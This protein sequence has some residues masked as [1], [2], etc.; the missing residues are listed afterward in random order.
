MNLPMTARISHRLPQG[1]LDLLRQLLLMGGAYALYCLVRGL[2]D[3]PAGAAVAFQN[4][5]HLIAVEDTLHVFV[6][7]AVQA[8]AAKSPA[9][10]DAS[11]WLYVNAQ[12]TVVLGALTFIYLAHNP[13]FY[14]V[15]NMFAVAWVLALLGYGLFPTAPPRLFPELGFFDAV[16]DLA[17]S[18]G[19]SSAAGLFNQYAAVPSMHVCFA[20]MV[21]V[22]LARLCAHRWA[23]VL[24]TLYPAVVV[25]VIVATANHFLTDAVLGA[26]TAGA[27]AVTARA[28]GRIRPEAWSW[29]QAG[30][31]AARAAIHP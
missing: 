31:D 22:P 8:W 7:P 23:R 25:F 20:L 14:F 30:G 28:L 29:L 21:A 15:R 24:W 12:T 10:I 18:T 16:T 13:S 11:S 6:E 9:L 17:G 26:V 4:A 2:V 3:G 27:A 5:R 1:P 19:T